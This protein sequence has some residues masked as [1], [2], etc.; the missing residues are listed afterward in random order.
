MS[1]RF[2]RMASVYAL[3]GIGLGVYMGATHQFEAKAVHV[4]SLLAGW[5][6][7]AAM[8]LI[9]RAFPAMNNRWASA[10]FWLHN[11]GLPVMLAGVFMIYHG[12]PANGEPFAA[13]GSVVLALGFLAFVLNVWLNARD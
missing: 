2:I 5:L 1:L 7:L 8:G 12:Q 13:I 10:H 3:L 4:H 9:Y 6:S 11:L